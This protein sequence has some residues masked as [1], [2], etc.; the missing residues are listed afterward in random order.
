MRS[1]KTHSRA[2]KGTL[3]DESA[4]WMPILRALDEKGGRAA[5][6]EVIERVG[7]LI[8][9]Q[10]LAADREMLETGAVRWQT[11]TQFARLR[12]KEESLIAPDSPRGIWEITD[13]G[14]QH[15]LA[16]NTTAA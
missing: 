13:K 12:M 5:A 16:G 1:K 11:R 8:D 7:E 9:D 2:K 3:L 10:L 14:T 6:S 15:L 4:Y